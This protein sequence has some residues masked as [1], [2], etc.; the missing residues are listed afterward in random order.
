VKYLEVKHKD[1]TIRGFLHGNNKSDVVLIFHGFTG[2]KVDHHGM[3]KT[4]AQDIAFSGFSTYRFDFLGSGD[5][6]GNFFEE[7]SISSQIEQAKTV[8]QSFVEKKY[9][10]HIFAFSMGGV[11]ATHLLNDKNIQSL[12]LL[13]PAG[14]FNEIL[15]KMI[16]QSGKRHTDGAEI[17]GFHISN[18]F[19]EEA[20]TFSY[21]DDICY[22]KGPVQLV[23]GTKDQYVSKESFLSY[24]SIFKNCYAVWIENADHCYSEISTTESVRKEII[25]F[26]GKI[27]NMA[28]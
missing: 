10:I 7:E 18:E 26:Y 12:F 9:K 22:F 2:N 8:I 28:I 19:I 23:Q 16:A 24:K 3:I 5:S 27:K 20:K 17:N 6:D 15:K 11:V 1:K 21:F 25:N 4:F 14:N 13:S